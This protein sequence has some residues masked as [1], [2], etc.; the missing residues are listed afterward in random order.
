[1]GEPDDL[2]ASPTVA[3]S[4]ADSTREHGFIYHGGT[5]AQV[6]YPGPAGIT[7][8]TGI[9]NANV[10][11]GIS[12]SQEP[13]IPFIYVSG[14]FKV[15]SVPN[16]SFTL[17]N[18][19][20]PGGMITGTTVPNGT[21]TTKGV[22]GNLQIVG[23]APRLRRAQSGGARVLST[24]HLPVGDN[25]WDEKAGLRRDAVRSQVIDVL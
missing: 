21:N 14:T 12:T 8:V 18:G 25:R 11:V 4:F 7:Q 10:V 13:D 23:L 24:N 1:V 16:A 20:A 22:H 5:W 3:G 2:T 6:D 19:I 9:S 17:L 15:I